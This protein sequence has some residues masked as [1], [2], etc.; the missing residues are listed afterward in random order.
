MSLSDSGVV[1]WGGVAA[2]VSKKNVAST[3]SRVID[4]PPSHAREGRLSN[5]QPHCARSRSFSPRVTPRGRANHAASRTAAAAAEV[6]V[7]RREVAARL[8]GAAPLHPPSP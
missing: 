5:V 4:R 2:G 1:R 6:R 8:G 3:C 7:A